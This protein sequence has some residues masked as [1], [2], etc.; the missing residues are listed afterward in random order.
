MGKSFTVA[1]LLCLGVAIGA[2]LAFV[3]ARPLLPQT[4]EWL[5]TPRSLTDFSLKTQAGVFDNQ[6]LTGRWTIVLFGFLHCADI[7]PTGLMQM[8]TLA[9]RLADSPNP[10]EFTFVFFS[11]DPG[12]DNVADISRFVSYFNA[13]FI[14]VTGN[15]AQL[16]NFADSLAIRFKLVTDKEQYSVTHSTAFSIIDPDGNF[17]GRFRPGF[18]ASSVARDFSHRVK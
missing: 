16:T 14:G 4:I 9:D 3:G 12:R 13:S 8:A 18:D 17:S 2:V 5:D 7:C 1:A 10:A 11:V 15:D 6:S